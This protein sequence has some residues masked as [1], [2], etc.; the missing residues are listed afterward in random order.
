M[1]ILT[2]LY[3]ATSADDNTTASLTVNILDVIDET[4]VIS[5]G[6]TTANIDEG[7]PAGTVVP[8]TF[9]VED[10]DENDDLQ[11]SISGNRIIHFIIR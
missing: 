6:G 11:Y 1:I 2:Y 9:V 10:L 8:F 4:P 5:A 3:R 7:Q